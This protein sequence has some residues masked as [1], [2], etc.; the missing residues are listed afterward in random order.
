MQIRALQILAIR[1]SDGMTRSALESFLKQK[2][3]RG[4]TEESIVTFQEWLDYLQQ[5][6]LNFITAL[7]PSNKDEEVLFGQLVH[8]KIRM[9]AQDIELLKNKYHT[10]RFK[11]GIYPQY[12][13]QYSMMGLAATFGDADLVKKLITEGADVNIMD[14]TGSVPLG[15]AVD[16]SALHF[17]SYEDCIKALLE[18]SEIGADVE[19]KSRWKQS[20]LYLA[21]RSVNPGAVEMLLDHGAMIDDQTFNFAK[22]H[23]CQVESSRMTKTFMPFEIAYAQR[24]LNLLTEAKQCTLKSTA[25]I[26][27]KPVDVALFSILPKELTGLVGSYDPRNYGLRYFKKPKEDKTAAPK[28]EENHTVLKPR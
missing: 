1:T 27:A 6:K 17:S 13:D 8:S 10:K 9:S 21:T 7:N 18:M 12:Y 16:Q 14:G 3:L 5:N 19:L 20:P 11:L 22:D 15:H 28:N 4:A 24:V 2:K 23:L 26:I 25:G